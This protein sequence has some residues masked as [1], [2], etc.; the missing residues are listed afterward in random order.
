[1]KTYCFVDQSQDEPIEKTE[2]E[3]LEEYYPYWEQRMIEVYGE[4]KFKS[5]YTKE[6]CIMDW[7]VVNWAW[8]KE[9]V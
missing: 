4:E 5:D 2:Q 6:D 3:I 1:L 9:D 7:V 8:E